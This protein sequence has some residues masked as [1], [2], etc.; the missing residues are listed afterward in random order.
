MS[1]IRVDVTYT[2]KDGS[3]VTF[4]SPCD[5]SEVTGLIVYYPSETGETV[6]QEF[7]YADAHKNDVSEL[8]ELFKADVIVKVL[9]DTVN[10]KAYVQNADTNAYLEGR[11]AEINSKM[12]NL[13]PITYGTEDL[14][15]GV[16]PLATG[17][18]HLVYEE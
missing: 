12:T 14:E 8:S 10:H 11:F 7:S 5:C 1:N 17:S 16:T 6:S 18:I 15:A 2:I 13:R 3:E 9:L 4:K